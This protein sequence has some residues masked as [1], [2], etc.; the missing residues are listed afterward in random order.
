VLRVFEQVALDQ[1]VSLTELTARL[2]VP[3][4]TVHRA[5]ATLQ[6]AGWIRSAGGQSRRW[7]VAT[8]LHA[9]I[10]SRLSDLV[11][12]ASPVLHELRDATGESVSL[13]LP[14]G[15]A[16]VVAAHLDGTRALRVATLDGTRF[17]LHLSATG[18][19]LLAQRSEEEIRRYAQSGLAART[20]RSLTTVE[21]LFDAVASVRRLGYGVEQDEREF[22]M[23]SVGAA[24][25]DPEGRIVA[26]VGISAP[27]AR[28]A[29]ALPGFGAQVR[30]AAGELAARLVIAEEVAS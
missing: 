18:K 4:T 2:G 23:A 7:V 24:V 22:G 30:E 17:P 5:L 21:E 20:D 8:R 28:L 14:D 3:T 10:G 27:T 9:L 13:S 29:R 12:R 16:V 1:P 19:V 11:D 15:D 6:R 25:C 26:G